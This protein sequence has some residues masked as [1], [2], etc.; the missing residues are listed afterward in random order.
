M[1]I[2][3]ITVTFTESDRNKAS[4]F[5]SCTHCLLSTALKRMGY[6]CVSTD[7]S[8]VLIAGIYYDIPPRFDAALVCANDGSGDRYKPSVVGMTI[9]LE[10]TNG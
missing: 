6:E 10:P 3:P 5:D 7:L 8:D 1:P 9:T 2:E 4:D